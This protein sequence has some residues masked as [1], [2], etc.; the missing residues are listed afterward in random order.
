M[1][2]HVLALHGCHVVM[3]SIDRQVDPETVVAAD[4]VNFH[5]VNRRD[6]P[7]DDRI[8]RTHGVASRGSKPQR[9]GRPKT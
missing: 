9:R 6:D 3:M 2:V 7:S 4:L 8:G 5:Q 1:A